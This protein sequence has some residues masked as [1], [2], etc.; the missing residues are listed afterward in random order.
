MIN[1]RSKET[2]AS[3]KVV[4]KPNQTPNPNSE[5]TRQ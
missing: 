5:D 2:E 1:I 4:D 3:P